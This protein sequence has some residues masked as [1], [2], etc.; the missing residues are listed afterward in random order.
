MNKVRLVGQR[1]IEAPTHV[2]TMFISYTEDDV[3]KFKDLPDGILNE[4]LVDTKQW[5]FNNQYNKFYLELTY[6]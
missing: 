4:T 3:P 1:S 6:D 2:L 5:S